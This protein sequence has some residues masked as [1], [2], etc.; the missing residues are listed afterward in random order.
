[1]KRI[2]T[3]KLLGDDL[4]NN[5]LINKTLTHIQE[6]GYKINSVSIIG[7]RL[8]I[9][10]NDNLES[11]LNDSFQLKESIRLD[12]DTGIKVLGVIKLRSFI[13]IGLFLY[14]FHFCRLFFYN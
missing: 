11:G 5:E 7:N 2:L 3:T 6:E 8:T 4:K 1:M 12:R 13:I 9:D 10:Y 14:L